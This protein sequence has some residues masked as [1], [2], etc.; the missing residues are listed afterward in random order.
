[1]SFST[2]LDTADRTVGRITEDLQRVA[3]M[4]MLN[5]PAVRML[6]AAAVRTLGLSSGHAG[7][8]PDGDT[9]R[10]ALKQ[11]RAGWAAVGVR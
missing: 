10:E 2:T 6:A 9:V 11:M 4:L 3:A 1:M 7:P 5:I 8:P